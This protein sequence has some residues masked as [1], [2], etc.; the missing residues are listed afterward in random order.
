MFNKK[1]YSLEYICKNN[2]FVLLDTCALT[3]YLGRTIGKKIKSPK[4]LYDES[5]WDHAG[6][7]F[8]NDAVRRFENIFSTK[9]IIKEFGNFHYKQKIRKGDI[10]N[11]KN[12]QR[13]LETRKLNME[14]KS[15]L[16]SYLLKNKRFFDFEFSDENKYREIS[17]DCIVLLNRIKDNDFDLFSTG[18]I[19]N[20]QGKKSSIITFDFDFIEQVILE[21]RGR[22]SS[23]ELD[24]YSPFSDFSFRKERMY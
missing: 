9:K 5:V 16:V 14:L 24:F 20:E 10:K 4:E 19:L 11:S 1:G 18:I 6:F 8:W 22:R 2:D 21:G 3:G 17:Q 23:E 15:N 7:S 12:Y 13:A